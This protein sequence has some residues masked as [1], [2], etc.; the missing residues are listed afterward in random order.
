MVSFG[1]FSEWFYV[2]DADAYTLSDTA[3]ILK[4]T[5]FLCQLVGWR[6]ER[7][8]VLLQCAELVLN[9]CWFNIAGRVYRQQRG[10]VGCNN[11]YHI[12]FLYSFSQWEGSAA[13]TGHDGEVCVVT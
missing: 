8:A 11:L 1:L 9:Q 4:K 7:T 5:S 3:G 13:G 10:M 6:P 2:V 12:L